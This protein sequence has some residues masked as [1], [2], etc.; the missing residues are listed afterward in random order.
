MDLER[1]LSLLFLFGV[2]SA[3]SLVIVGVPAAL[4]KSL[5]AATLG[6]PSRKGLVLRS[7]VW[8]AMVGIVMIAVQMTVQQS[9]LRT[10]DLRSAITALGGEP[11]TEIGFA[12]LTV[13]AISVDY[14][15]VVRRLQPRVT[16]LH[17]ACFLLF[18]NLWVVEGAWLL[19]AFHQMTLFPDC[20]DPATKRIVETY[21]E[22]RPEGCEELSD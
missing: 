5:A 17:T 10:P 9:A 21:S 1:L 12:V 7:I 15:M 4:L 20:Y 22:P 16:L 13:L 18:S 19:G 2:V 6:A 3:I 11:W 8:G 14:W